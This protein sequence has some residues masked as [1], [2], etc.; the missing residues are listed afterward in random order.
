MMTERPQ[1]HD[2]IA[3]PAPRPVGWAAADI[4][5]YFAIAHFAHGLFRRL[6]FGHRPRRKPCPVIV[7]RERR[8]L[9][10]GYPVHR[11]RIAALDPY[12]PAIGGGRAAFRVP[13]ALAEI[14]PLD[15]R[16]DQRGRMRLEY[17]LVAS[18]W[19]RRNMATPVRARSMA[20][21]TKGVV[22][23]PKGGLVMIQ[24]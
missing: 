9:P 10:W 19:R 11:E 14:D 5:A 17:L 3:A 22:F 1:A 23:L 21:S 24:S 16:R 4:A 2:P 7:L 12:D 15:E 6:R 13:P 20:R 8:F 18:T